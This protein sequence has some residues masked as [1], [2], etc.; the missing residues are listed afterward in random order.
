MTAWYLRLPPHRVRTV[1]EL[2]PDSLKVRGHEAMDK[3]AVVCGAHCF[4]SGDHIRFRLLAPE[5]IFTR[6]VGTT[7]TTPDGLR[8]NRLLARPGERHQRTTSVPLEPSRNICIGHAFR[9]EGAVEVIASLTNLSAEKR[10]D[11][12]LR[13]VNDYTV[14]LERPADAKD[15]VLEEWVPGG[16]DVIVDNFND[17]GKIDREPDGFLRKIVRSNQTKWCLQEV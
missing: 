15:V 10:H 2:W 8:L 6:F 9:E 1:A 7:R 17:T 4:R 13:L 5:P 16:T 11:V 3:L 12:R 14:H